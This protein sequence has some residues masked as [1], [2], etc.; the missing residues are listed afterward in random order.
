MPAIEA[1][2]RGI[3]HSAHFVCFLFG[4]N[5]MSES[6]K[7]VVEHRVVGQR[8]PPDPSWTILPE[9]KRQRVLEEE[10]PGASFVASLKD[11][12]PRYAHM[13]RDVSSSAAPA[14]SFQIGRSQSGLTA[15]VAHYL[16]CV[17][18]ELMELLWKNRH[19]ICVIVGETSSGKTTCLQQFLSACATDGCDGS[20]AAD[21]DQSSSTN[22]R[23]IVALTGPPKW[24]SD[25]AIV[26]H[27]GPPE[28]AKVW[29]GRVGLNTVPSWTR[30]Y[31]ILSTGEKFRADLARRLQAAAGAGDQGS[32]M[33]IIDNFTSTLDRQTAAC[34]A[35]SVAKQLRRLD[36]GA[37]LATSNDDIMPWLQPDLIITLN[38]R[39]MSGKS[40]TG[41]HVEWTG[42]RNK[43]AGQLPTVTT[44]LTSDLGSNHVADK[45]PSPQPPPPPSSSLSS[46]ASAPTDSSTNVTSFKD[47]G[48]I[49]WS[50]LA[51]GHPRLSPGLQNHISTGIVSINKM[52][53]FNAV[54][55]ANFQFRAD[56][57]PR[58]QNGIVLKTSVTIDECTEMC[59][60]LFDS[61]FDGTCTT[62]VPDFPTSSELGSFQLG[63]ITGPSG[64]LKS[65]IA[66]ANFGPC[67]ASNLIWK[68]GMSVL[69][70][71]D[72][73]DQ[74]TCQDVFDAV[75]LS[76]ERCQNCEI[77]DLSQGERTLAA[78]ARVL[79][80]HS[81]PE[82]VSN[83]STSYVIVDEFTSF[84]D[85][86]F[87][88][89]VAKGVSL[90][91]HLWSCNSVVLVG[92]HMDIIPSLQPDWVFDCSCYQFC[93]LSYSKSS[94]HQDNA[95]SQDFSSLD[96]TAD[97]VNSLTVCAVPKPIITLRVVPCVPSAWMRFRNYHYKT[98]NLSKIANTFVG[99]ARC[100]TSSL[101]GGDSDGSEARHLKMM[102]WDEPVAMVSTI[103]HNGRKNG[104]GVVPHRAHRTVVLPSWQGLGIGS[105]MSDAAGELH[106]RAGGE[107]FGQTVHP[108]F[109]GYRDRSP[110][111]K[112]TAFNHTWQEFKIENWKQR[113]KNIRVRLNVPR[114]IYSHQYIGSLSEEELQ[115]MKAEKQEAGSQDT[116]CHPVDAT[117][118]S[119][120]SQASRE[121]YRKTRMRI[122]Y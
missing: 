60:S 108:A 114:F 82:T 89:E 87:A 121:A 83:K 77:D 3:L 113:K 90:F 122:E 39:Q 13:K 70:H 28:E 10:F 45:P 31:H 6:T 55:E 100:T 24:D 53:S 78:L 71:F 21:D 42:T 117:G 69:D 101:T 7:A 66:A 15:N 68:P 27:F 5:P 47:A 11:I 84:L 9:T 14:S 73:K 79:Y 19:K 102:A 34:C 110:L 52:T 62:R 40:D 80:T 65:V 4:A 74:K 36:V 49:P 112:S 106:V 56:R 92:C 22:K 63:Y 96:T 111:W 41:R 81:L 99:L 26:S 59:D 20:R 33:L 88:I 43:N 18:K 75:R 54:E 120:L 67:M 38:K 35:V 104:A 86:K 8:R 48:C 2:R 16:P 32:G 118:E 105:H 57:E 46:C 64:S 85:R 107:Y 91:L 25:K 103:R 72:H 95:T 30:P 1:C 109:G 23:S 98:K 94:N 76:Y 50:P 115:N 97:S 119:V 29:L 37:L 12:A 93:R 116:V 17:P 51:N 44:V 61:A 58:P